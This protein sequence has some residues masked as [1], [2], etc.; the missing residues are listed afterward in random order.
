MFWLANF[1]KFPTKV[2]LHT[3]NE[4]KG[5][6]PIGAFWM[7]RV[8]YI[9]PVNQEIQN[10]KW[11]EPL[12]CHMIRKI[13]AYLGSEKLNSHHYPKRHSK[14]QSSIHS[15]LRLFNFKKLLPMLAYNKNM[16]RVT[17]QPTPL[18]DV[19]WAELSFREKI[20]SFQV[21]ICKLSN[22]KGLPIGL[23]TWKKTWKGLGNRGLSTSNF[24]EITTNTTTKLRVERGN[25]C[26]KIYVTLKYK[27]NVEWENRNVI[28]L[29]V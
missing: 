18:P 17:D 19:W 4:N 1:K 8:K 2:N 21:G 29:Q 3:G 11:S 25:I 23:V 24:K 13:V 20:R 14:N 12:T 10:N 27:R 6:L 5:F 16:Q 22:F 7:K 28:S 9:F 26:Q 15:T